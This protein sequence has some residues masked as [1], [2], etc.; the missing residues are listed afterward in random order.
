[1]LFEETEFWWEKTRQGL[2]VAGTA[3]NWDNFKKEFL[4]K[5]FP[6]NICK[7][8]EIEFLEL[9]QGNM[10]VDDYAAKFQEL[11]RVSLHCNGVNTEGS[12]FESGMHHEIKKFIRYQEI[13]RFSVL[14]NKFMIYNEDSRT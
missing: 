8:K 10:S 11:S 1:M 2:E 5:Y 14:V 3:I 12:K 13:L 6:S 7:C 4:D 9:K